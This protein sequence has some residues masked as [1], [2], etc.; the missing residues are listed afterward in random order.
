[1]C[2]LTTGKTPKQYARRRCQ[3][4]LVSL[5]AF[6]SAVILLTKS[7]S[8]S[9]EFYGDPK[10]GL[11]AVQSDRYGAFYYVPAG[12]T[13]DKDWPLVVV[14]YSDEVEKGKVVIQK[15]VEEFKKHNVIGLFVSYLEPRES[16]FGS[17][18][19]LLKHIRQIQNLY[20]V[21]P[22]RILLTAFGE[23]AHYTFY[24]GFRYPSYFSAVAMIAG[25]VEGRLNPFLK[26]GNEQGK[27][28]PFLVVYGNQDEVIWKDSFIAAHKRFESRGYHFEMEEFQGLNHKLHPEF[29]EK[30][31]NWFAGLPNVTPLEQPVAETPFGVPNYFSSLFRGIF[32]N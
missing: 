26:L 10:V 30:V 9:S 6:G 20:R 21:D 18:A 19:R 2:Y 25:G 28:L 11:Q 7:L 22:H 29:C 13:A 31:L 17:D 23:A 8:A 27:S 32:K 15:W 12:Y 4:F 24:V 14:I 1:M 3:L 5:I 16:P